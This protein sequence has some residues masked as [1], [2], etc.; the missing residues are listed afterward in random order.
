MRGNRTS[1]LK[2]GQWKKDKSERGVFKRG[3][4]WYIRF[5]DQNG[6]GRVERVGPSKPLALKAYAKRKTE[7]AERRFFPATGVPF[8]EIVDDTIR[9]ARESFKLKHPDKRFKAGNYDIVKE[10]FTGRA[11][12]SITPSEI[13]AKLTGHTQVPATF[14]RF[15]VAI[16]HVYKI[17]VENKKVTENPGRLVKLQRENNERVRYLNQVLSGRRENEEKALRTALQNLYPDK[18]SEIDLALHTG[19][20]WGEQYGL[21]WRNVD[22]TRDVIKIM[23]PKGGKDQHIPINAEARRALLKL[24]TLAKSSELVCPANDY[25]K[26][27]DWWL[28]V[29]EAAAIEDF[30]WHDL[31]HTFASRLVMNGVD[32]F[33]VCRL[34]GHKS[35]QVTMRYAHLADKHL[36]TAIGK[37]VPSDTSGDTTRRASPTRNTYLQ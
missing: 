25:D 29:L 35:I 14:N 27:R 19:M 37:L 17:A 18:E 34:M 16:S 28:D 3:K 21:C 26:H 1:Q 8:E 10:W 31:R 12:D 11:A 30:H 20:R 24:K 32:I 22:L 5:C 15:R 9:L 23:R 36:A 6:K 13:A 2:R 7:I 33:T 4:V